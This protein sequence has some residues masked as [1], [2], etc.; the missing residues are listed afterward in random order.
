MASVWDTVAGQ[1]HALDQ[2]RHSASQPVHA[3]LLIGP[4]GCGKEE[5]A[6]AFAGVLLSGNDNPA[7]RIND[8]ALRGA[9]PDIT[10]IRREGASISKDQA[11]EAIRI[12]Y[13]TAIEGK[14][15]VIILHEV[16]LMQDAAVVRLLKTLEEPPEGVHF[17]LLADNVVSLPTI[18]S[19]CLTIHFGQLDEQSI[20]SS[21]IAAGISPQQADVAAQSAGGSLTRA[22][23]LATD[24]QLVK[25]REMFANI[26]RRIDSTGATVVAIV[27]QILGAI[28]EAAEPL[29]RQ[30]EQEVA[31]LEETLAV[32]GV[33][34]GGKKQLEDRHKREIRRHR[35]DE[36]RAGLTAVAGVYRDEL[37]NNPHIHHRD[38]YYEAISKI[39]DAMERFSLNVNEGLLLRNL[40]WSIPSLNTDAALEFLEQ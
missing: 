7:D 17:I 8:L 37:V 39:H 34:R 5:A 35:T 32:M 23:L 21:L 12:A 6:R 11:E 25:R 14:R 33:K 18:A 31:Q 10:E 19:R 3:Y 20:V 40:F 22:R 1:T 15:K 4:E 9:H 2:L 13:T 29:E 26:P 36:L 30:H 24:P 16:N 38:S 27:D 28:D